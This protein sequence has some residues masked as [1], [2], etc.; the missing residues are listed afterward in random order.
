V[1]AEAS[2]ASSRVSPLAPRRPGA[3]ARRQLV[4]I[5]PMITIIIPAGR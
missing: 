5:P 4:I 1:G 2:R 3:M